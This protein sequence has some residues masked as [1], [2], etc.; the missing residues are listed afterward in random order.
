WSCTSAR[1]SHCSR[2]WRSAV[3]TTPPDLRVGSLFSGVGGIDM[4]LERAGMR[5]VWQA[6]K[7]RQCRAVLRR[8]WPD[9]TLYEDVRDVGRSNLAPIDVLAAGVPCQDVSVAGRR[10]GLAGERTGLFFEF[11][12]IADELAPGWLVFENVPG[13]LSSNGGEDFAVCL[14]GFT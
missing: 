7:D 2:T 11:V 4:G 10:A 9:V 3:S 12:R 1:S 14:E 8:H 6:E 13:L 5:V